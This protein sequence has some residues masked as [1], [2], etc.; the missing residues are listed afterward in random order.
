MQ[1]C[2]ATAECDRTFAGPIEWRG[3]SRK[4]RPCSAAST[5]CG[6]ADPGACFR[7]SLPRTASPP[8]GRRSDCIEQSGRRPA[9]VENLLSAIEREGELARCFHGQERDREV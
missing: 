9:G 1:P 2:A 3:L 7:K 4:L 6:K 8:G 5:T